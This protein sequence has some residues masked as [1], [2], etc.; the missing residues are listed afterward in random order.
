MVHSFSGETIG[1]P[2][3][4]ELCGF[5]MGA[6]LFPFPQ[7]QQSLLPTEDCLDL[8][9]KFHWPHPAELSYMRLGVAGGG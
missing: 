3:V 9:P 7:V 4:I 1:R 2:S 5:G 8:F 6:N